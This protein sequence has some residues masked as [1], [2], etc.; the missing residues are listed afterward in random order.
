MA[1]FATFEASVSTEKG[2]VS[3]LA[4]SFTMRLLLRTVNGAS[5][6]TETNITHGM[7]TAFKL[8][9]EIVDQF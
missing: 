5:K 8:T 2:S 3:L 9:Q 6:K 7:D 4:I 1:E